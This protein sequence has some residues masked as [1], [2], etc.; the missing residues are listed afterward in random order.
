[1]TGSVQQFLPG[2]PGEK[3]WE[4]R[5]YR[6]KK[7]FP[8]DVVRKRKSYKWF[9]IKLS[10]ILRKSPE[11]ILRLLHC[12]LVSNG[13]YYTTKGALVRYKHESMEQVI[14]D[15][16]EKQEC[17]ILAQIGTLGTPTS[18]NMMDD[19]LKT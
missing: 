5:E 8:P 15:Y 18:L 16:K 19:P 7:K 9:E 1:M 10:E 11:D 17:N 6:R 12:E 3:D 2:S 13:G 14:N 4:K